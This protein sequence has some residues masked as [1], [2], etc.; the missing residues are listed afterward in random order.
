[1]DDLG[2]KASIAKHLKEIRKKK[3]LSLDA[4]AKLTGVSKAMLGQI[5]REES[6]PTIAKLWRIASGLNVSFSAF[7]ALDNALRSSDNTFPNDPN[8]LVETIFPFDDDTGIE[9]FDITLKNKHQQY[10]AAHAYGVIEHI[11]V[12]TGEMEV[13]TDGEWKRLSTG[14]NFKFFADLPHGYR[15][16]SDSVVFQNIVYYPKDK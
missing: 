10:S 16:V 11:V 2:F 7:F 13:L 9:V 5:E 12:C 15:A 6:S 14:E 1:M 8:M 4:T 3:G